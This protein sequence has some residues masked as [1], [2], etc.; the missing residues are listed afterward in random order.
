ME[1][2]LSTMS[3]YPGKL[4]WRE[5]IFQAVMGCWLTNYK[6]DLIVQR[7]MDQRERRMDADE[8]AKGSTYILTDDDCLPIGLD[9]ITDGVSVVDAHPQF[10]MFSPEMVREKDRSLHKGDTQ[11]VYCWPGVGGQ[12]F[13]RKG[14]VK[15]WPPMIGDTYDIPHNEAVKDRGY[16]CGIFR[17]IY[18][19]HLCEGWS[20]HYRRF[21][22]NS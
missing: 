4:H 8:R 21:D 1:V 19:N 20:S 16:L 12:R 14:L 2:F 18:F 13:C 6:I 10:G 7:D 17:D 9:F 22:D 3:R 5:D 15:D 11:D